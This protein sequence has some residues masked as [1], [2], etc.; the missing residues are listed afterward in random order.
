ME[1]LRGGLI[2]AG[3]FSQFHAEAWKRVPGAEIVAVADPDSARASS[4]AATWGI[5]RTHGDAAAL[6]ESERPDFIDIVTR[7]ETHV[8]LVRLAA[9]RKVHAI[10]QKP[11]APTAPE[12]REMVE[13]CARSGVRLLIHE[14]WRWQ[15]WFRRMKAELHRVGNP[16]HVSFLMRTGDG[17]GPDPYAQQPY[18]RKMK[19][20]LVYETAVHYLD[21][22]R[23]LLG[24]I[25][26]VD[27]RIATINPVIA[28]EDCALIALTFENG[29]HGVIDANRITGPVPPPVTLGTCTVEGD[30]GAL[31]LDASGGLHFSSPEGEERLPFEPPTEGYRGDSVR[32]TCEHLADCLRR[33]SRAESEG[34]DYLATVD[35]VEACYASASAGR[36]VE[37]RR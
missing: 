26:S 27:C 11:M 23:Y 19:R 21:T 17:R 5:P 4:F 6:I 2:G 24:E 33:G 20:L 22:F 15:A 36:T 3:F 29:A 16:F 18:F 35:L 25:R 8:D 34:E 32:A 28:G 30:R 13:C 12:C 14:N 37:V 10:C 1:R 7:P 9:S 31:R